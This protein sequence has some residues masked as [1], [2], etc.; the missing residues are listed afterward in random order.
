MGKIAWVQ[1]LAT[2]QQFVANEYVAAC[3]NVKCD[4]VGVKVGGGY[5]DE[6]S[7]TTHRA[8]F[9][10]ADGHYQIEL[11]DNNV[12]VSM[13]EIKT[14]KLGDLPCTLY[15][16]G[17]YTKKKEI[18]TVKSGDYIY[19]TTSSGKRTWHHHGPVSGTSNH[20]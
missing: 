3:W 4:V 20:S 17:S 16:D 5:P 13:T 18:A 19:W 10:G 14:D 15:E 2:V 12:P 6:P 9:C 7:D 11:N 1:P 8:A